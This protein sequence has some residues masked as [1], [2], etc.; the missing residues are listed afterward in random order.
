MNHIELQNATKEGCGG[1]DA[2]SALTPILQSYMVKS[3]LLIDLARLVELI[4]ITNSTR[5]GTITALKYKD[6]IKGNANLFKTKNGF[7]NACHLTMIHTLDS[8]PESHVMARSKGAGRL[9]KIKKIV[10]IKIT[11]IG[12]FQ[13]VGVPVVDVEKIIYKVFLAL[14]KLNK[15]FEIF[16]TK[17]HYRLEIVIVPIL[18]NYVI[19]LT[20][21][22]IDKIFKNSNVQIIHKFIKH[23]FLSFK[24]DNDPAITIKRAYVY[25]E[26]KRNGV[27][28]VTWTKKKGKVVQN[29]EYDSYTTLLSGASLQNAR[30][31]KYVTFR[32]Y[33]T[34]K[35]LISGFDETLVS[36]SL[37]QLFQ[38]IKEF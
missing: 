26:F 19:K 16:Q 7:K 29:I 37:T 34:G 14:E 13:V 6:Y 4:N 27:R 36:K 35:I 23:K 18:N 10:H 20:N 8:L 9:K 2:L 38:T 25:D 3:N 17:T 33:T 11:A 12:T 32:L 31:K 30:D 24:I 28:Y 1:S 5:S 21:D 15:N 22:T